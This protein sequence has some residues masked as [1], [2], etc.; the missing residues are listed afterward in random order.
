MAV[1]IT[2]SLDLTNFA[3]AKSLLT[4]Q[5]CGQKPNRPT[6]R[7]VTVQSFEVD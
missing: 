6:I 2:K 4:P 1:A 3:T 7:I 5:Y